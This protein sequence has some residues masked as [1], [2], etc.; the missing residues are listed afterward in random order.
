M[1]DFED[2]LNSILSSPKDM[3]KIMNLAR[4]I[5][6]TPSA[7][8]GGKS[9]VSAPGSAQNPFAGINDIDPKIFTVASRIFSQYASSGNDKSDLMRSIKPYVRAE[10]RKELDRA[11]EIAKLARIAKIAYSEFSGGDG[12]L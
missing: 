8:D 5:G 12:N 7:E 10:R 4:Q 1:S 3:E 6:E 2:R 9:H 11:V